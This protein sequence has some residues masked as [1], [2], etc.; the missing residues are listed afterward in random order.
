MFDDLKFVE[1]FLLFF[2]GLTKTVQ[3]LISVLFKI[4]NHRVTFLGEELTEPIVSRINRDG[5]RPYRNIKRCYSIVLKSLLVTYFFKKKYFYKTNA[6]IVMDWHY[7]ERILVNILKDKAPYVFWESIKLDHS[8]QILL[9]KGTPYTVN[10]CYASSKHIPAK[11]EKYLWDRVNDPSATLGYLDLST[12]YSHEIK[13]DKKRLQKSSSLKT[14]VLYLHSFVDGFIDHRFDG[15]WSQHDYVIFTLKCLVKNKAYKKIYIKPHPLSGLMSYDTE[16]LNRLLAEV[17]RT[18]SNIVE[19]LP[20]N[21]ELK[22]LGKHVCISHH[23]SVTEEA[24]FSGNP[25]ITSIFGLWNSY[26][27]FYSRWGNS[28]ELERLL[29]CDSEELETI[30]IMNCRRSFYQYISGYRLS[31]LIFHVEYGDLMKSVLKY[32][33]IDIKKAETEPFMV[34]E[35]LNNFFNQSKEFDIFSFAEKVYNQEVTNGSK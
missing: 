17:N 30:D 24:Y 11:V 13:I 10:K 1:I 28:K 33:K 34:A 12:D 14:A 15:F 6:M 18:F 5:S 35:K 22:N 27:G 19:I 9:E 31:G 32:L 16:R 8:P 25:V 2:I 21:Y 26:T 29:L 23:G 20:P 3:L 4:R 7:E